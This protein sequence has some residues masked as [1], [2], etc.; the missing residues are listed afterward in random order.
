LSIT[1]LNAE[2]PE[3]M[4]CLRIAGDVDYISFT[5]CLNAQALTTLILSNFCGLGSFRT[6]DM[7]KYDRK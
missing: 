6:T 2:I 7:R 1:H 5:C 4:D 3:F